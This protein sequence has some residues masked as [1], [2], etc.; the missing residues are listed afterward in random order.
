MS[1]CTEKNL[2]WFLVLAFTYVVLVTPVV[3]TNVVVVVVVVGNNSYTWAF[4]RD[5]VWSRKKTK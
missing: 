4:W 5:Q 1:A 2:R 3:D